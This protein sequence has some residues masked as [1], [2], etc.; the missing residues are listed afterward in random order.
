MARHDPDA[1]VS[2]AFECPA[3]G[4][5]W[6]SRF[7]IVSYFWGELDDWAQ[8]LLAEVH[9]LARAYGW[10]EA[11]ILALS[12]TRRRFYLEMVGV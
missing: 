9:A 4:A 12:P 1:D 2:I 5:A 8:R 7:D 3:C 10:S 6:L 11:A